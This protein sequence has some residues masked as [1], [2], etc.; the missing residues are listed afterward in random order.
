MENMVI[1]IIEGEDGPELI[2]NERGE[3]VVIGSDFKEVCLLCKIMKTLLKRE[4]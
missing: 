3:Q 2:Y 1:C 4:I